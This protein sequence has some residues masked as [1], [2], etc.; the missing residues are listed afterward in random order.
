MALV[1]LNDFVAVPLP[2]ELYHELT[3][4]YPNRVATVL[5]NVARD[6]LDRTVEDVPRRRKDPRNG[7]HW[8]AV[9]LPAGTRLRTKHYGE[10][11]YA[12]IKGDEIIYDGKI[13]SSISRL[14]RKMRSNTSV[15]AWLFIELM[16]PGDAEWV[17]ADLLRRAK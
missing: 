11:K 3:A 12:E 8:D 4:R 6:F 10:Y 14:A 2:I 7:V 1:S 13:V 17:K 9:F 5:E 16:R 15:N